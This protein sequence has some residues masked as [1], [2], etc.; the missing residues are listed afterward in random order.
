V[1]GHR[2]PQPHGP[3]EELAPDL[4]LLRGSFRAAPL[5]SIGRNM[6]VVRQGE[7]LVV[8]NAVRLDDAGEKALGQLG[9]VTHVIRL[10]SFHGSDD[11]YFQDRFGATL[12]SVPG[13]VN[14][15]RPLS[16]GTPGPL[17]D[18]EMFLFGT[19]AVG[20]AAAIIRRPGGAVLITCD[21]VQNWTEP[22]GC[23]PLGALM[24]R[25]MG[26]FKPAKIGPLW[27][28]K[29]TGGR[30]GE[31]WPQFER[32]LEKDFRHLVP[33][34]GDPLRDHAHEAIRRSL[35][36]DLGPRPTPSS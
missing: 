8:L 17:R 23:S 20:E 14:G 30:P 7:E 22:R 34:H 3:L 29:A 11:P 33:G 10:G 16:D 28:K 4:F 2:P 13:V 31:L 36:R 15:A 25:A 21:S 19:G 27:A 26:F 24:L 18:G 12:W 9:A 5:L 1:A 32:L 35:A 6:T